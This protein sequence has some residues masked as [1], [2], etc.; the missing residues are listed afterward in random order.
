MSKSQVLSGLEE[1][2]QDDLKDVAAR[3]AELLH[4]KHG[5]DM[6]VI[7]RATLEAKMSELRESLGEGKD[8]KAV[9]ARLME[10]LN[11]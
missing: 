3:V 2:S 4:V 7:E 1:M 9:R 6:T 10:R 8:W 5:L 11:W